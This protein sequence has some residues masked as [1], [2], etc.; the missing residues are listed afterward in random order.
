MP[1]IGPPRTLYDKIWD[2]HVVDTF[3]D[4][5]CLLAVD[6]QLIYEATSLQAFE[7][8]RP[9]SRACCS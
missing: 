3:D 5:T 1:A 2:D 4:G 9:W 8:L 6:R 7:A